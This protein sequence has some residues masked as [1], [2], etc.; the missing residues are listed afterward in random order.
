[1]PTTNPEDSAWAL[2]NSCISHDGK[3]VCAVLHTPMP[4]WNGTTDITN[5]LTSY[6][7]GDPPPPMTPRVVGIGDE[8]L[9]RAYERELNWQATPSLVA[10]PSCQHCWCGDPGDFNGKQHESCCMCE[11]RRVAS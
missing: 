3:A 5:P 10:A 11:T 4:T 7:Y 6:Y 1:M 9:L 8:N 2:R